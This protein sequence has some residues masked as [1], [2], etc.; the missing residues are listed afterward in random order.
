MAPVKAKSRASVGACRYAAPDAPSCAPVGL[1]LRTGLRPHCGPPGRLQG[2]GCAH[3]RQRFARRPQEQERPGC[4]RPQEKSR[5]A[6]LTRCGCALGAPPRD[7]RS[8][9]ACIPLLLEPHLSSRRFFVDCRQPAGHCGHRCAR[10]LTR[11]VLA[12]GSVPLRLPR[13]SL[14]GRQA[15]SFAS[16][17]TG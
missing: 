17:A 4:A 15:A 7:A 12:F 13:A 5:S 3:P 8:G 2:V 14:R 11:S 9:R 10:V 16:T 1:V 6:P